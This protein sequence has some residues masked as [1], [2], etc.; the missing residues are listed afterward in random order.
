MHVPLDNPFWCRVS[1][2]RRAIRPLRRQDFSAQEDGSIPTAAHQPFSPF[3]EAMAEF[4]VSARVAAQ[5][6]GPIPTAAHQPFIVV[7]GF[8][9]IPVS[10]SKS[11]Q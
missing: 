5:E 1:V 9:E 4:M 6:D 2:V 7:A 10:T 11:I 3:S 8:M